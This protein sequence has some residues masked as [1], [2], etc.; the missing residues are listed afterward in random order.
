MATW[1]QGCAIDLCGGA[2]YRAL[3]IQELKRHLR[4][5]LLLLFFVVSLARV[6]ASEPETSFNLKI[7]PLLKAYCVPCHNVEKM[8]SGVRVDHLD[9]KLEDRHLRLWETIQGMIAEGEMPPEDEKQ[10]SPE[11]R[12]ILTEWISNA[13]HVARSREVARDGSVR[14]LT[15][16][17]YRNAL[18]ELLDLEDD[19][20][21]LLPPEAISRDGFENNKDA[22]LLSPILLETYFEIAE[23]ALDRCLVD[24]DSRPTIQNFRM[25]LG[26]GINPSP[27]PEPL[28]LGAASRLLPNDSFTVTELTPRKT[29]QYEPFF[30]QKKFRFVEGYKGNSTVRGWRDYDSI[31]HA[32]Y[33]CMRG[34]GGYPL[35]N[36]FDLVPEGLLLRPAIPSAELFQVESTYGPK[37]NFKISLRQL[38]DGGR[39]RVTVHAARYDDGLLL[40]N[41]AVEIGEGVT[42]DFPKE[43]PQVVQVE[44]AGV[45]QVQVYREPPAGGAVIADG[46]NLDVGRIGSWSFDERK[47]E[48][49]FGRSA[50]IV[51]KEGAV[52][53]PADDSIRVGD[54][55]FSVA[56]WIRPDA[57]Q[58]GGIVAM[59][60]YGRRG[61]VFDMPDGRGVLRVETFKDYQQGSGSIRSKPGIIRKGQWQHVAAVVKRGNDG[62]RLYVN[63]YEVA[64]G[65]VEAVD[66]DNLDVGLHIGRIPKANYFS[67]EIDEVRL[68][69]RALGVEEIQ[70]LIE[71]GRQFA[72][73]PPDGKQD[74]TVQLGDRYF[75]G[76]LSK[77]PF[78]AVR[79]ESGP[80]KVATV[81]D[82][83]WWV[84]RVVL[85]PVE[86]P[87]L[88]EQFEKRSPI[89]GVHF[90]L[91]RDCGHTLNPVGVPRSVSSGELQEFVFEGAINN[92]PSPD[93]EKNNVN[94]ISGLREI[95]VRSEYTDGRDRA[96]LLIRSIEFE[97]PLYETW[98]PASHRKIFSET[99]PRQVIQSFATRAFRRPISEGEEE[100]LVDLYER[101]FAESGDVTQS[102]RD[103][104]IV[105]LTS[106][107]FL[108][109]IEESLGPESELIDSYEL[110]SKIAFFLWNAP[111]DRRLLDL[112]R[113]NALHESLDLEIDRMI[114]DPQF[115]RFTNAFV[116]QWL[117]LDKLDTVEIDR[118]QFPDL[119]RDAKSQLRLEPVRFVEHLIRE[120]LPLRHLVRSDLLVAN[121]VVAT[122]YGL[123]D[124]IESGFGFQAIRHERPHLGGLLTQ[125]GILAALSDGREA[126]PIKR[127]A[128]LARKIIAEPPAD[129]PPNVPE[130]SD[131]EAH[132]TLRERLERHRN[133]E[134]CVKCHEGIDPWGFPFEQFDAGG[135]FLSDPNHDASSVLPD[136]TEIMD[137]NH[138]KDYLSGERIDQVAFSFLKHLATYAVGRDLSY[139]EV[140]SLREKALDSKDTEYQMRDLLRFVIHSDIFQK[141]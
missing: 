141:K 59:G 77:T 103:V 82:G 105:I 24:E 61:W 7:E 44:K 93:V 12:A 137:L 92:F 130:L 42:V 121:E 34:S 9:G 41:E 30:M 38:P 63:G 51:G 47:T 66:L 115:Q 36:P 128:W 55:D 84:D 54:G 26:K 52:V 127:G 140:E 20:S 112:A 31:Y 75:S 116:S 90:G 107:Q 11:E 18:W 97:G 104:L 138:L 37:A 131:E 65:S 32:V 86:N 76:T 19:F 123:G 13:L 99:D 29:F 108:F 136:E 64:S 118:K 21:D 73:A 113:R 88:F 1:R 68:Y 28:I 45:Y 135:R 57:L 120:N 17:Q 43:G 8:K 85:A 110:A 53:I 132:L 95:G 89:L 50:S 6:D 114:D 133:Q 91:R 40:T 96:R 101:S 16:T 117:S 2:T 14:R 129:P 122:Y 39:F 100:S 134:G 27:L 139:N 48:S 74:L 106:P 87:E 58:Q 83:T 70:A 10:P 119:T 4:L 33:A 109:L 124:Q 111:P 15:V 72:Q 125:A 25:D 80:L 67:G 23:K 5:G 102:V 62:T 49:P 35:G 79:L 71:P 56:A 81:Y 46:T 60:P 126:N 3:M 69:R 78:V 94:Y 98:P 22:M